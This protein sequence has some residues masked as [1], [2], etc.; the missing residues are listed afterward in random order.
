GGR[1]I[2]YCDHLVGHQVQADSLNTMAFHLDGAYGAIREVNDSA[3]H[4]RSAVVDPD[5]DGAAVAKISNLHKGAQ[6]QYRVSSGQIVHIVELTTDRRLAVKKFAVPGGHSH[7]K[8]LGTL[9]L[10]LDYYPRLVRL[11]CSLL[12][13]AGF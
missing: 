11:A 4:D 13:T 1:R 9:F 7:L 8:R 2:G 5:Y 10:G 3:I 6:R 12:G